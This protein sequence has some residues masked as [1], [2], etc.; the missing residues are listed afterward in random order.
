MAQ[1]VNADTVDLCLQAHPF[2]KLFEVN[3]GLA[4]AIAVE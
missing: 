2:P 3:N 4:R 1:I